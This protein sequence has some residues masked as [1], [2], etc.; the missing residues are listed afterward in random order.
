MS[1]KKNREENGNRDRKLRDS[2]EDQLA[3]CSDGS[4]K[5]PSKNP[6]N[7]IHELQVHQIE[8]EMQNEELRRAQAELDAERA[9]YFNI[10]DPAPVGYCTLSEKGLI[11]EAIS[12]P[13]PCWAWPEARWSNRFLP[14]LSSRKTR[15]STTGTANSSLSPVNRRRACLRLFREKSFKLEET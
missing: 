2:A 11:H 15:T 13:P 6:E 10:Y 4:V 9:R 3:R 5:L 14:G 8:M 7:L 12:P 1:G